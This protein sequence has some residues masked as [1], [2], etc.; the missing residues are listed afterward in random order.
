[1]DRPFVIR[2]AT[3]VDGTGS[4]AYPGMIVLDADKIAYAGPQISGFA[5]HRVMDGRNMIVCP[6][7]IDMHGHS[8]LQVFRSPLMEAKITQ[9]ITTE[10]IGNCGMGVYPLVGDKKKLLARIS[11]DILG[12]SDGRW[13]WSDFDSYARCMESCGCGTNVVGMQAHAPLRYAAMGGSTDRSAS[14]REIAHMVDLL[15]QAFETGA[16]GFSTGLYYAPCLFASK[17]ELLALLRETA[18]QDRLCAVH[19]RCE[20][21]GVADSLREV[22]DLALTCGVRIEISHLKAIGHRNQRHVSEMLGMLESYANRG[23]RV[24]FDFALQSPPSPVSRTFARRARAVV[25]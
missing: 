24:G 5:S 3:I 25:G 11:S 9:G 22:L 16:A 6:G 23:L 19:H 14:G 8:D 21:D 20:G 7:F 18:R 13:P 10:V 12:E 17:E 4:P 15:R 2:N 1:M